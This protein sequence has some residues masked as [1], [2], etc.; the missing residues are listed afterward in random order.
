V[1]QRLQTWVYTGPLGHLY[2]V[3][4][5]LAVFFVKSAATR[6]LARLRALPGGRG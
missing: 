4:V 6:A 2:S 5:D 1:I 3:V